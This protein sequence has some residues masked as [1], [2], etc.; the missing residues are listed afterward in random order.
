MQKNK[1]K[2]TLLLFI[3][4]L[5]SLFVFAAAPSAHRFT[6]NVSI[7]GNFSASVVDNA[8]IE[9]YIA[10]SLSAIKYYV[11]PDLG[12]AGIANGQ[13][14]ATVGCNDGE[15]I[16]FRIYGVNVTEAVQTCS[17]GATTNLNLS[18]NKSA[19]GVSCSYSNGCSGA[20][21]CSGATE[22][23]DGSGSGTCQATA[24]VAATTPSTGGGGS[25]GGGGGA[26][27]PVVTV[28]DLEETLDFESASGFSI[29]SAQGSEFSFKD[30]KENKHTITI[31]KVYVDRV[32]LTITSSPITTTVKIGETKEID[33]NNDGVKDIAI[34]L[35][36]IVYGKAKLTFRKLA[37]KIEAP[38]EEIPEV[39]P[40]ETPIEEE[41]EVTPVEVKKQ[42][43]TQT[44]IIVVV[45]VILVLAIFFVMK[46][47]NKPI[48]F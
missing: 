1:I 42:I 21:C 3:S 28:T 15:N 43:P 31:T 34:K 24:C 46:K 47:K 37:E 18:M 14:V 32:L 22:Y 27:T 41:P 35:V 30:S 2:L 23:T 44:I 7:D 45:I 39:I 25:S 36:D 5:Y 38:T 26:A 19:N 13:Y 29:E 48:G 10:D 40:E 8:T 20:Y 4:L 33:I 17:S 12:G 11:G 6:G 16:K 9:V